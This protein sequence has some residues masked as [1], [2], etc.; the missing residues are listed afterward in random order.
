[1]NMDVRFQYLK[2]RVYQDKTYYNLHCD[3][4]V[5]EQAFVMSVDDSKHITEILKTCEYGQK[6]NI[7]VRL[8]EVKGEQRSTYRLVCC[9]VE[10]Y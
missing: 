1:M 5:N 3:D 8:I 7:S 4:D 2:S 6:L 10:T 9:D